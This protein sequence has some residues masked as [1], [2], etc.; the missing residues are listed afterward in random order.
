M[1]RGLRQKPALSQRPK[2]TQQTEVDSW[3]QETAGNYHPKSQHWS[4]TPGFRWRVRGTQRRGWGWGMKRRVC[5]KA[6]GDTQL[7]RCS[8]SKPSPRTFT[9]SATLGIC[10]VTTETEQQVKTVSC[11]SGRMC[12]PPS[13]SNPSLGLQV[14][15][16]SSNSWTQ[17]WPERQG[18]SSRLKRPHKQNGSVLLSPL[19]T[20]VVPKAS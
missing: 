6:G 5:R 19:R 14:S 15:T 8:A 9:P 2:P 12:Q 11:V 10:M 18:L 1:E 20:R 7:L 3:H 17:R 16:P 4:R 13:R